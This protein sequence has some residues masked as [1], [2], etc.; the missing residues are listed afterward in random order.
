MIHFLTNLLKNGIIHA[1]RESLSEGNVTKIMEFLS[2]EVEGALTVL[3]TKGDT[4]M[5]SLP[6]TTSFHVNTKR[7]S[8]PKKNNH[9]PFVNRQTIGLRNVKL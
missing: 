5:A 9:I 7:T 8:G 6:P 1:K 2:N 3:K 4:V